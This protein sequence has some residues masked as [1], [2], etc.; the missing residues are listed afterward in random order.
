MH[1]PVIDRVVSHSRWFVDFLV[2]VGRQFMA[3]GCQRTAASLSYTTALSLVPLMAVMFVALRAFP[4]FQN[5]GNEIQ[6]YIFQNF[7]PAAGETMQGHFQQFASKARQLTAVGIFFL[8]VIAVMMMVTIEN[9]FNAIWRVHA[10]RPALSSFAMYW[11]VLTLGPLLIGVGL[12]ATSYVV[13]LPLI[14]D[15]EVRFG[16]KTRFIAWTPFV[17]TTLAFTLLYLLVPNRRVP[18]RPAIIGGVVAALLFEISK[19]GFALYV[20]HFPTYEAIYGAMVS[21][22]LFLVW[23]YVS[24]LVILLGAEITRGLVTFSSWHRHMKVYGDEGFFVA[25]YRILGQLWKAQK[26]GQ[27][28]STEVIVKNEPRIDDERATAVIDRLVRAE[29]VQR[30]ATGEWVLSRDLGQQTLLQLYESVPGPLPVTQANPRQQDGWDT[31][32]R[33]VLG[34]QGQSM[35]VS[36]K[37]LYEG[38]S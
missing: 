11:A 20:T 5:L 35:Q 31:A 3:D 15:A 4:V 14:S 37:S 6:E 33:A 27:S 13:S 9:A 23:V 18:L 34:G 28:I 36:L 25:A 38:N 16:L 29:W 24:W 7:V 2:Y 8:V 12:V 1:R 26:G 19:R 30:T 10:K 17:T 22:P 21:I 32:L